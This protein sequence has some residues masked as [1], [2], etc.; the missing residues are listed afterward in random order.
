MV[1]DAKR[2]LVEAEQ[3]IGAGLAAAQQLVG[4]GGV[5]ADLVA[6]L[7]QRLDGFLQMRKGRVRQTA[8]VDH[9][10]A[11]LHVI[12]R[13]LHDR[14]DGERRGID[15]LGEDLNVVFG[16]VGGLARPAEILRDVLEFVGPAQER[17]AEAGAQA[18]EIGAAAAG[19]H[20]LVGLDRLR[21]PPGD[22]LLG[23][24][25][26]DLDPDIEHLPVE[27]RLD[28]A[29]HGLEPGPRQMS[30]QEQDVFSHG[31]ALLA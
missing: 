2:V 26:R 29:E 4:V 27:A 21:Q 11:L 19:Q 28:A 23:H 10:G 8:E 25:G 13:A 18:V 17:H 12:L 15:D 7:L 1:R 6:L 30:G 9:I 24:Q 14:L 5:D 22:D 3:K 20:D 16:H 31:D